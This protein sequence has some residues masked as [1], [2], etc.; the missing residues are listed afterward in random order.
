MHL[1]VR[2]VRYFIVSPPPLSLDGG[3][4]IFEKGVTNDFFL[5]MGVHAKWGYRGSKRGTQVLLNNIFLIIIIF[6]TKILIF[7]TK[8]VIFET[9]IVISWSPIITIQKPPVTYVSNVFLLVSE[10][11][12]SPV[13][14]N[15]LWLSE[16]SQ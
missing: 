11:I 14:C 7:R 2:L 8:I 12:A 13:F 15:T 1:R 16:L 4:V 6:K 3:M 10:F 5:K 9:K